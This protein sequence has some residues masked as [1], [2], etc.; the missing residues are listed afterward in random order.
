MDRWLI[1]GLGNPGSQYENTRHNAGFM[2]VRRLAKA[3]GIEG[4]GQVKF[5]A[6]VG[7]GSLL[8]TPVVLAQPTTFMN[9]SGEAVGRLL[10]FYQ[11]PP[12]R[13]LVIYDDVALP[14]GKIR[15]RPRGSAGGHN[16]MRSIIKVLGGNEDF[17]RIRIGIN[18]PAGGGGLHHH[19]LS[20]FSPDEEKILDDVL[21]LT[22]QAVETVVHQGMDEA[23]TRFNGLTVG[24]QET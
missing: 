16:G 2:A 19:V 6:V 20:R 7:T 24:A 4:K 15:V 13:L 3:H 8:G 22:V 18:I 17:P 5:N 9:L 14:L 11:V 1:A 12:Q 23:M 21:D 10:H